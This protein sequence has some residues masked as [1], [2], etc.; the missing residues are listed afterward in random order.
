MGRE[1]EQLLAQ[2]LAV[3]RHQE[4][5]GLE[6]AQGCD[7][8]GVLG[9]RGLDHGQAVRAGELHQARGDDLAAAT[10]RSVGA[11]DQR[12]SLVPAL[13]QR[14]ENGHGEGG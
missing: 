14:L 11:S 2:D 6:L 10:A 12:Q 7:E 9:A 4:D 5:V 1:V 3:A 13:E 8:L